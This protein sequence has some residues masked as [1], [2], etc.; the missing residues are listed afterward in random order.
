VQRDRRLRSR[1]QHAVDVGRRE[2]ERVAGPRDETRGPAAEHHPVLAHGARHHAH[3]TRREVVVVEARVVLV[4]PADQPD[5]QM[6]VAQ[7]RLVAAPFRIVLHEPGPSRGPRR[8]R[9]H[10]L[11]ELGLAEV[12]AHRPLGEEER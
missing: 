2:G 3:G 6:L 4:H 12:A 5:G 9:A 8:Q 1:V 7:Q 10:E 11:H